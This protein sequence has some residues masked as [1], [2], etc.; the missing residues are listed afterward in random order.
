MGTWSVST[1]GLNYIMEYT[2]GFKRSIRKNQVTKSNTSLGEEYASSQ[3]PNLVLAYINALIQSYTFGSSTISFVSDGSNGW[4]VSALVAPTSFDNVP[5]SLSVDS[6]H[7][8]IDFWSGGSDT[9]IYDNIITTDETQNTGAHGAGV[10]FVSVIYQFSDGTA[11]AVFGYYLVDATDTVLQSVVFSGVQVS[12]VNGLTQDLDIT[13][14]ETNCSFVYN[15]YGVKT[16]NSSYL[17]G[18]DL[19]ATYTL[20][21]LTQYIFIEPQFDASFTND[22]DGDASVLQTIIIS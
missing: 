3:S 21:P 14:T 10:Y 4:N 9:H 7:F 16:D 12:N 8:N 2:N 15:I 22:Y 18:T 6:T 13:V 5:D 19:S 11:F 20:Q 1:S 17:L